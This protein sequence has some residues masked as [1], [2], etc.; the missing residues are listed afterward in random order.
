M[1]PQQPGAGEHQP[2]ELAARRRIDVPD[3]PRA[4]RLAAAP[5]AAPAWRARS[6]SRSAAGQAEAGIAAAAREAGDGEQHDD[7]TPAAPASPRR[8]LAIP[9]RLAAPRLVP[10]GDPLA[11]RGRGRE[12]AAGALLDELLEPRRAAR[13]GRDAHRQRGVE[14]RPA[15]RVVDRAGRRRRPRPRRRRTGRRRRWCRSRGRRRSPRRR[16]R[17]RR[18]TPRRRRR[19]A[20]RRRSS[21]ARRSSRPPP[22]RVPAP[23][24]TSASRCS[25]NSPVA[26][27]AAP[28]RRP[29]NARASSSPTVTYARVFGGT[30]SSWLSP[31]ITA[32]GD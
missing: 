24:S 17:G 25:M 28:G 20:R 1:R 19:P 21:R 16:P 26:R 5:A 12:A 9:R 6:R 3:D 10:S 29:A 14:R 32:R 11:A 2:G 23:V 4:Q 27:D 18:R 22:A 30:T 8:R 15:Q 31:V 7:R 13:A